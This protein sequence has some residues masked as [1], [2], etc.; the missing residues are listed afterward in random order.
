MSKIR[1]EVSKLVNPTG[2]DITRVVTDVLKSVQTIGELNEEL[3]T[4]TAEDAYVAITDIVRPKSNTVVTNAKRND[5]EGYQEFQAIKEQARSAYKEATRSATI[6]DVKAISGSMAQQFYGIVVRMI[7]KV[8]DEL[9]RV[10]QA[11]NTIE[12]HLGMSVT[13]FNEECGA[14]DTTESEHE[15]RVKKIAGG[16][17]DTGETK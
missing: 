1:E 6:D 15:Q 7:S 12:E 4:L 5:T 3:K 13:N 9:G 11:V 16:S 8:D 2:E 14:N 17:G 10:E